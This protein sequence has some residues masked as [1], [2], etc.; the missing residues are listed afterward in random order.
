MIYPTNQFNAHRIPF[1]VLCIHRRTAVLDIFARTGTRYVRIY[2]HVRRPL[3]MISFTIIG[4]PSRPYPQILEF[5][6]R[7]HVHHATAGQS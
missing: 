4:L 5:T 2:I 7:S 6:G 3:F 1:T